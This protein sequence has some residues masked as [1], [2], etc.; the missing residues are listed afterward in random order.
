MAN[1]RL[2][3]EQ[4]QKAIDNYLEWAYA[5]PKYKE[6][7]NQLVIEFIETGV[8]PSQEEIEKRFK[9]YLDGHS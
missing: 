8:A 3:K 9:E 2:T 5:D 6:L 7:T 1:T 4:K